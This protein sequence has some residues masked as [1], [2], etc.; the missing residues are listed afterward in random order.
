M[1]A[2]SRPASFRTA[3][4]LSSMFFVLA[5]FAGALCGFLLL[6]DVL[7]FSD[8]FWNEAFLIGPGNAE[9]IFLPAAV[10]SAALL[11]GCVK[12]LRPL[13]IGAA[14]LGAMSAAFSSG[15]NWLAFGIPGLWLSAWLLLPRMLLFSVL[16]V[17]LFS[18][19]AGLFRRICLS[20][21]MPLLFSMQY[22]LFP[23]FVVP[24]IQMM[25]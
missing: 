18:T 15:I 17:W 3:G 6:R 24:M 5:F 16:A 1:S 7:S 10:F 4:D 9:Q 19:Q 21:T 8:A 13:L 14:F 25:K 2:D 20:M 22:I 12:L 11:V 23:Y